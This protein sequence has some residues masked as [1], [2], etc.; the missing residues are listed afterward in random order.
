[1]VKHIVLLFIVT[2]IGN[3]PTVEIRL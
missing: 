2:S 1:M 3:I